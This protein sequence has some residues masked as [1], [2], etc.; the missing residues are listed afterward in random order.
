MNIPEGA[1]EVGEETYVVK[2]VL[3][4]R[5]FEETDKNGVNK[6]KKKWLVW[7]EGYGLHE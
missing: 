3:A 6:V 5:Y 7:W 1:S 4:E 2:K